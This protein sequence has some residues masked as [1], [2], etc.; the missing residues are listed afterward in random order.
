[1]VRDNLLLESARIGF[2]NFSGEA[3]KFNP[4]GRRNFCVFLDMELGHQLA[5]DGWTIRWT[6]PRDEDDEPVP[7]MQVNLNYN[8]ATM[9]KVYLIT[10][11]RK[12]LLDEEVVG[13]LDT[14]EISNVDILIRP[15]NWEVNGKTGV[16]GY[17]K[18]MVV[19]AYEDE[20]ERKYADD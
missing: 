9:P 18:T 3:T 2:R 16:K 13:E 8:G 14:I 10:S 5:A 12:T 11:G 15:Y 6:R 4:A 7:Y 19:T 20:L 1:M 17:V